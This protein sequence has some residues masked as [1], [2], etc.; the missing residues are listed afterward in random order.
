[1]PSHLLAIYDRLILKRPVVTLLAVALL[2]VLVGS[3]ARDFKLDASADS[4]VLENDE[5]LSYY[6]SI[7][8]RYG[9]D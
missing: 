4:L 3:F 5:D 8:A 6:R 9:S 7:R 2:I 1:M